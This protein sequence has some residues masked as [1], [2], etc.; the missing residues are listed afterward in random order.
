MLL[1]KDSSFILVKNKMVNKKP[2]GI[3]LSLSVSLCY[4][5]WKTKLLNS[6]CVQ[7]DSIYPKKYRLQ[8]FSK[9]NYNLIFIPLENQEEL[10]SSVEIKIIPYTYI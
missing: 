8:V 10:Q 7:L 5:V 3:F 2:A 4:F 9:F 1:I 6:L